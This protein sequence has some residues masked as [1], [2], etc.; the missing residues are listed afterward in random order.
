MIFLKH[1]SDWTGHKSLWSHCAPSLLNVTAF[2]SP[3]QPDCVKKGVRISVLKPSFNIWIT[4]STA[5]EGTAGWRFLPGA[6]QRM[7]HWDGQHE[8]ILYIDK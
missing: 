4:N 5:C 1:M 8:S 6:V 2:K 7:L 3:I